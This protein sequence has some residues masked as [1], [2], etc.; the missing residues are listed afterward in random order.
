MFALLF[1]LPQ[2]LAPAALNDS[3]ILRFASR[4]GQQSSSIEAAAEQPGRKELAI[5]RTAIYQFAI[6]EGR[7]PESLAEL[8]SPFPANYLSFLFPEPIS[9]SRQVVSRYDGKGGWVYQK[10]EKLDPDDLQK[11]VEAAL[12]PNVPGSPSYGFQP[13]H[14][15]VSKEKHTISMLSGEETLASFPVGLGQKTPAGTFF[16]NRR[17]AEP[18]SRVPKVYGT[19]GMELSDPVYAIHGTYDTG[20]IG[21]NKS[22]GC[23]RLGVAD[24]EELYAMTPLHT[25]VTIVSGDP[26]QADVAP[27]SQVL[28][29]QQ[30]QKQREQGTP[31]SKVTPQ[32]AQ[33]RAQ[34]QPGAPGSFEQDPQTI[35]HWA[36]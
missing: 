34:R 16:V 29:Y 23:I 17:V 12:S 31:L 21:Q 35:Y 27:D 11:Q 22:K 14:L 13:V 26:L 9:G 19:R 32:A 2:L 15:V 8:T 33:Q 24:M 3:S 7:F 18:K 20:S 30:K 28:Q 10:P 36:H 4:T 6:A 25:P 5:M 1:L